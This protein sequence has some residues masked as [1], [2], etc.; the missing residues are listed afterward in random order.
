M[1]S[2]LAIY[3]KLLLISFN[4][5]NNVMDGYK[6][7]PRKQFSLSGIIKYDCIQWELNVWICSNVKTDSLS[8]HIVARK[9]VF[10]RF[11]TLKGGWHCKVNFQNTIEMRIPFFAYKF[12]RLTKMAWSYLV[13]GI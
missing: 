8:C 4:H 10:T 1:E 5:F 13:C 6:Q 2:N 3:L 7:P 11:K 9:Y 12:Q